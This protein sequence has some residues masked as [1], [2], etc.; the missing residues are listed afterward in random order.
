MFTGI[1]QAVGNITAVTPLEAG[2]RLTVDAG[3][4]ERSGIALGDSICVQG[5]CL[6][7]VSIDEIGRAHV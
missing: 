7:V 2:V 4:L 6:T 3:A 1:V 5:A